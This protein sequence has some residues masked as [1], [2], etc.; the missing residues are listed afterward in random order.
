MQLIISFL[1]TGLKDVSQA[2]L[3]MP[4]ENRRQI[5]FCL[6]EVKRHIAFLILLRPCLQIMNWK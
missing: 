2:F 6:I 1:F 5:M 3:Y 4:I